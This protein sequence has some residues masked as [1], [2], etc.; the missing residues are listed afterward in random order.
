MEN[1]IWKV[2]PENEKYEVSSLG[3]YK[4][5]NSGKILR[6]CVGNNGYI[7]GP[8]IDLHRFVWSCF[9]GPIPEDK[10][11]DHINDNKLDNR[12]CNL[13]L[14]T[15]TE[16]NQKAQKNRDMIKI[17][18]GNARRLVKN[19]IATN[20]MT[21]EKMLFKS[22]YQC[23]LHFNVSPALIYFCLNKQNCKHL[24]AGGEKYLI[25]EATEDELK[26]VKSMNKP[27]ARIGMKYNKSN[28]LLN[29]KY[30]EFKLKDCPEIQEFMDKYIN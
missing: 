12:L 15:R 9:N 23:A 29:F 7:R 14:L 8:N 26:T 18:G 25:S 11:V 3:R 1:E 22:K 10:Q 6:G 27:D 20:I 24:N 4:N 2:H 30:E 28:R 21:E 19:I 13:Q 17:T 16:N 5:L